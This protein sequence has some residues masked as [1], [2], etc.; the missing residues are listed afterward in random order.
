MKKSE[1]NDYKENQAKWEYAWDH[2]TGKYA[3]LTSDGGN[4]SQYLE[5]KYQRE[6]NKAFQERLKVTDPVLHFSTVVDGVNGVMASKEEK[7]VRNWGALGDENGNPEDDSIAKM[8]YHNADLKGTNWEPLMKQVGIM[9]TALHDV[10][11]LV[12]GVTETEEAHVQVINPLHVVDWY[13]SIGELEQVLVKEHRDN[14]ESILDKPTEEDTYTLFTL[15]GFQRLR[16]TE[17]GLE[18]IEEGE[19]TYYT[20]SRQKKK[21]LPIFRTSIPFPRHL[22][23]L[24]ALKE[25]HIFNKKSV[26]DFALRNLSFAIL[27][28]VVDDEKQYDSITQNLK[29]GANVLPSYSDKG[30]HSFISPDGSYVTDFE[31]VLKKDIEDFYHNGFKKY[32]EAAKQVTA[33]QVKLES[34][35]GIEAFL[36]LLVSSVDEF[37]NQCLKRLEQVYF[38]SPSQWGLAYVERSRDFQ[39]EELPSVSEMAKAS[40]DLKRSES[41]SLKTRVEMIHPEW[42]EEEVKEEVERIRDEISTDIPDPFTQGA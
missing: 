29:A 10:W 11:G 3:E 13:P 9:L 34:H 2:Y 41:A 33:T 17:D 38:D 31:S 36:S 24:L 16:D 20:D 1:H 19:Y 18:F 6:D 22:G 15:E 28:L 4:I 37:E 27:N 8:I 25:N 14:R 26:R 7:T 5:Q 39:P 40:M 21:M 12:E 32:G 30:G 35:S 42:T 23:Y